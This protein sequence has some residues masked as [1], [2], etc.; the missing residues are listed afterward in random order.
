MT[1]VESAP[2]VIG[3]S[4]RR[5]EDASLLRGLGTFV[6][7]LTL[8]ATVNK[9]VVRSAIGIAKLAGVVFVGEP[10]KPH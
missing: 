1:A 4:V 7:N 2:K 5:K 8:P 10:A 3:T 6:D 9:I